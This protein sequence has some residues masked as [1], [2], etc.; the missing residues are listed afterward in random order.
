[1]R[2]T[3]ISTPH[4][5]KKRPPLVID[6]VLYTSTTWSKVYAYDAK[7]GKQLWQYDPKIDGSKGQ[8]ACCDVVNRGLAA[9][10]GKV[11]LGALDGRLIAID[12]KTGREVWST[13]T[14]DVDRPYTITGAP[15]IVKGK[16]V[17][18]NGGAELGVRG[19]VSAYDAQTGKQ[20]WRFYTTP[21]PEN[22]PDNAASDQILMSK[23]Y[24]TWGDGWWKKT[25]GGGTAWDAIVY[26]RENNQVLIGTGNG[27]PWA[28]KERNGKGGGL[29][30]NLFLSSIVAVDADTGTYKWHYQET[31]GE[32]WD[33]TATQPIILA[34]LNIQESRAKF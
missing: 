30:D 9:Y 3:A 28:H 4:V 23:A 14:T 21:N 18:G 7:T 22:K 16:V 10:D 19:Y 24:Q 26:D 34:Q 20:V 6:G 31:P 11:Y 13:Q 15:R 5:V 27:S 2:G 29:A 32:E 12:M 25:G 17:I 8:D 33:F 1:M